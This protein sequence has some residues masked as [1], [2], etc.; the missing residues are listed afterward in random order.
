MTYV[1]SNGIVKSVNKNYV[2]IELINDACNSCQG[3]CNASKKEIK[4]KS[5]DKFNIGDEVTINQE[6]NKAMLY[7]FLFYGLPII[8]LLFMLFI[9][10]T[11]FNLS[12]NITALIL[13]LSLIPAFFVV[14]V[15]SKNAIYPIIVKINK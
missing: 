12:D 9:L 5:S 8:F 15:L 3:C 2:T 14:K 7:T 11:L 6:K 4:I 10:K 13:I 1:T